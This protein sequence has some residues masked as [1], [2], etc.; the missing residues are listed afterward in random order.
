MIQL[1]TELY[2]AFYS[3]EHGEE[4]YCSNVYCTLK[5]PVSKIIAEYKFLRP[6]GYYKIHD[7]ER[8]ISAYF[9]LVKN[10]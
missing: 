7:S 1:H 9:V 8:R 5:N 10:V 4:E 6:F 2:I 3:I